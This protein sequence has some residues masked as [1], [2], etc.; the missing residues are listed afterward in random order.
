MVKNVLHG[1][2]ALGRILVGAMFFYKNT[3]SSYGGPPLCEY[4]GRLL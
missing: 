1:H 3:F 2:V 4:P